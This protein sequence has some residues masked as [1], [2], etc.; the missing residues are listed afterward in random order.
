MLT[1]GA[2]TDGALALGR[3]DDVERDRGVEVPGTLLAVLR[4]L[5]LGSPV[6]VA[7]LEVGRPVELG[8]PG[9]LALAEGVL[10]DG[11]LAEGALTLGV[12][13]PVEVLTLDVVNRTDVVERPEVV[14]R[15]DPTDPPPLPE[16]EADTLGADTLGA[17]TLGAEALE[18]GAFEAETLGTDALGADRLG[19]EVLEADALGEDALGTVRLDV[20]RP[21]IEALDAEAVVVGAPTETPIVPETEPEAPTPS[22]TCRTPG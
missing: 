14:G 16:L 22:L 1:E 5:V 6:D 10:A 7:R 17:E 2:L 4:A 12:L 8:R 21:G 11:A 13:K 15:L 18:A 3:P 20:D 19:A 9:P